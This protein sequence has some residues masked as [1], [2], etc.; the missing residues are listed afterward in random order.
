MTTNTDTQAHGGGVEA[1]REAVARAI[2]NRKHPWE[3]WDSFNER[4]AARGNCLHP[5]QEE[6]LALA[7]VAIAILAASPAA[8]APAAGVEK[9]I[10]IVKGWLPNG[11]GCEFTFDLGDEY[12]EF[13]A[14][15]PA[16]F[17]VSHISEFGV[18]RAADAIE[19]LGPAPDAKGER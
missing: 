9:R 12:R 2:F 7:D 19:A 18:T 15:K 4:F 16:S 1:V 8:P 6:A 14:Q 13:L 11:D 10:W 17:D 5:M 3:N